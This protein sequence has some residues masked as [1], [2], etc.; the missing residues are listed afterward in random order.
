MGLIAPFL[1]TIQSFSQARAFL[2]K[3]KCTPGGFVWG[4]PPLRTGAII[5]SFQAI[6]EVRVDAVRYWK[7]ITGT[8]RRAV[9]AQTVLKLVAGYNTRY[10]VKYPF[11][12]R[13][14]TPLGAR[15][16]LVS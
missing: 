9:R 10:A 11:F 16:P 15:T 4:A 13:F 1:A 14:L 5:N 6:G 8:D 3:V 12:A 2:L 7:Y